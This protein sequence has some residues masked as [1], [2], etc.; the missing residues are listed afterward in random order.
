MTT[1]MRAALARTARRI[2]TTWARHGGALIVSLFAVLLLTA[3]LGMA[4]S[5]PTHTARADTGPTITSDQAD[6]QPGS[7]VTL[8]HELRNEMT[9][10]NERV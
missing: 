7:T 8:T 2:Q 4:L 9:R 3:A 1:R 5:R 6:Y 10:G